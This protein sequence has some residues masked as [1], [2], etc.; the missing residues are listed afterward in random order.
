MAA[1][2]PPGG[3]HVKER[4]LANGVSVPLARVGHSIQNSGEPC[5]QDRRWVEMYVLAL[6]D[7]RN[8]KVPHGDPCQGDRRRLHSPSAIGGISAGCGA[9]R[10]PVALL[11][12]E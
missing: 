1:I 12:S 6:A 11:R 9:I 2:L 10:G 5:E 4:L 3:R 7:S 8:G